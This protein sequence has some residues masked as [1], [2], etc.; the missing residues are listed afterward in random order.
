MRNFAL[1][2]LIALFALCILSFARSAKRHAS[3]DWDHDRHKRENLIKLGFDKN[4]ISDEMKSLIGIFIVDH[5]TQL[6]FA[7][8]GLISVLI[9]WL[10]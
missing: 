4:H 8:L 9:M 3:S 10:L 2:A 7:A 5:R 1:V 6:H